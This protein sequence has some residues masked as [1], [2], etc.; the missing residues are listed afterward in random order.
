VLCGDDI[1]RVQV[2]TRFPDKDIE[3]DGGLSPKTIVE[4]AGAGANMIVAG[5][6]VFKG[7]PQPAIRALR[8]GV[9]KYGLGKSDAEIGAM[10]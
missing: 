4:A 9:L 1:E 6:S 3:V 2:R 10:L 7:E 5:S 8:A